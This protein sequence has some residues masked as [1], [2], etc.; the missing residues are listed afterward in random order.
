MCVQPGHQRSPAVALLGN[1]CGFGCSGDRSQG[2]PGSIGGLEFTEIPR[3]TH[4][5][6][7][8]FIAPGAPVWGRFYLAGGLQYIADV[9]I[10]NHLNV[11]PLNFI[12]VAGAAAAPAPEPRTLGLAGAALILLGLVGKRRRR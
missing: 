4:S 6:A 1:W 5:L 9:G 11:N 7:I 10:S 12:A 3:A 8:T 2:A